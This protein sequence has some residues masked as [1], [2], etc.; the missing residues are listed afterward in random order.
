MAETDVQQ[1]FA[2]LNLNLDDYFAPEVVGF[3]LAQWPEGQFVATD[4]T[5]RVVGALCGA[6]LDGGRAS[7]SLLAVDSGSRGMG[8]GSA[9]LDQFRRA[10]VMSG[11]GMMQ[12][13]VRTSNAKG[14]EFYRKRGFTI[15]ERLPN[16]YNDGG[17]GYRMVCVLSGI[18]PFSEGCR[19]RWNPRPRW[20]LRGSR[21]SC[22]RPA[23]QPLGPRRPRARCCSGRRRRSRRP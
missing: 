13:E 18:S 22:R 9:L 6:R 10:C 17:D 4:L 23:L 20:R 7:V 12:L 3:F 16:F 11:I 15:S 2:V 8:A 21:S 19:R 1:V 5:G 14:I